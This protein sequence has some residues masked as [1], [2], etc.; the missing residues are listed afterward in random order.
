MRFAIIKVT[1]SSAAISS[2]ITTESHI[3]SISITKGSKSTAAIWNTKV[4]KNDIVAEIR[5]L[6]S[7]VKKDEPKMA[8]PAKRKEKEKI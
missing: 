2:A 7:A 4:R 1:D 8:R 5:P 3:P 6:F